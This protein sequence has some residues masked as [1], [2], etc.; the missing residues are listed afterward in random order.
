VHK[1]QFIKA[2]NIYNRRAVAIFMIPLLLA[3]VFMIAYSP[4]QR[5]FEAY[6]RS[7]IAGPTPGILKVLP[8]AI[9]FMI[10]IGAMIPLT[11]RNDRD[12]GV[13]CPHCRRPLAQLKAI[14]IASKNCPYCGK[15]VLDENP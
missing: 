6:L 2:A 9:P 1:D 3:L 4:F 10:A 7:K 13:P 12:L 14:V 11:R 5:R 15:Q 8:V